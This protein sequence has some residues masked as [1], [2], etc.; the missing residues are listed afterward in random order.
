MK[1]RHKNQIGEYRAMEYARIISLILAMQSEYDKSDR[2]R[3]KNLR[4]FYNCGN[5]EFCTEES[6]NPEKKYRYIK[7]IKKKNFL[8]WVKRTVTWKKFD[9]STELSAHLLAM[10]EELR[11]TA[12]SL[13]DDIY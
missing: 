9:N 2:K 4:N 8:F 11:A 7:V 3:Q 6:S 13:G 1:A 12:L 5:L 10:P